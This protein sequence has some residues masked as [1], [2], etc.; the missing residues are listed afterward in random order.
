MRLNAHPQRAADDLFE[1]RKLKKKSLEG[2]KANKYFNSVSRENRW[3]ELKEENRIG[4][5]IKPK[6]KARQVCALE[7]WEPPNCFL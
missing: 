3:N 2:Q 6:R 7:L 4:K 5:T 1:I